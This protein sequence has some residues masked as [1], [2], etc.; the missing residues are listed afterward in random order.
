MGLHL[1]WDDNKARLNL[2]NHGVSFDEA[3]TVFVDPLARIFA[4]PVHSII[5]EREIIIGHSLSN[6]L[7]LVCFTERREVVRIISARKAT[8]QERQKYEQ[9]VYR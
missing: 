9:N 1:E 7:L 2:K 8:N 4:D 5:E 6:R 3:K